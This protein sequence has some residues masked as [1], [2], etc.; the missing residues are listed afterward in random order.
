MPVLEGASDVEER[1]DELRRWFAGTPFPSTTEG[2]WH[3]A[4]DIHEREGD[5]VV[6]VEIPGMK[7]E[8]IDVSIERRHLLVEG[9][10]PPSAVAEAGQ[11]RYRERPMG[12]FHRVIH[13]SGPVDA[14]AAEATY[15]DGVL[16]VVLPRAAQTGGRRIDIR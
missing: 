3:P 15:D 4:V 14:D 12:R 6:E 9:S 13:L 8:Q 1:L 16:T 11:A 10:R 7:G 2:L 5:I